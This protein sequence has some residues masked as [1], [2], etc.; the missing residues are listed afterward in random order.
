MYLCNAKL[1]FIGDMSKLNRLSAKRIDKESLFIGLILFG[2]IMAYTGAWSIYGDTDVRFWLPLGLAL[3]LSALTMPVGR[4]VWRRL[5]GV[6]TVAV[7]IIGHF[8]AATGFFLLGILAL[9]Y[10]FPREAT[11]HTERA[12]V[13]RKVQETRHHSRRVGRR[14][15]VQ[16]D[17]YYVYFAE[18]RMENGR[19]KKI[20]ISRD[21]Y[22]SLRTGSE[23]EIEVTTG[24]LGY[25]ILGKPV[26]P[27]GAEYRKGSASTS[28]PKG[29]SPS[30]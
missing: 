22:Y 10:L 14:R 5:S 23:V 1:I 11:R 24:L 13:E 28:R 2:A 26:R 17:P 9:N 15:Y 16:G 30:R 20:S 25:K 27:D 21:R 3:V 8:A 19:E 6:S 29:Y 7:H 4:I 18:L 12:V